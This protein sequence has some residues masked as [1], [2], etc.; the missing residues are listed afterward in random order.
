MRPLRRAQTRVLCGYCRSNP[1]AEWVGR[2]RLMRRFLPGVLEEQYKHASS[3]RTDPGSGAIKSSIARDSSYGAD[4]PCLMPD[5]VRQDGGES[6]PPPFK[7]SR[8]LSGFLLSE[9]GVNSAHKQIQLLRGMIPGIPST[10][11]FSIVNVELTA[12]CFWRGS[13]IGVMFVQRPFSRK[14]R[15]LTSSP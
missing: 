3:P 4:A 12:D 2:L 5:Q 10:F 11:C 15:C 9:F 7:L 13:H 6:S 14:Q 8:S 1:V